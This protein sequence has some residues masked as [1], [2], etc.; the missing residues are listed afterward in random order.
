MTKLIYMVGAPGAGKS[1]AMRSATNHFRR[2]PV[3][4]DPLVSRD[5]IIDHAG[6]V[7]AV[8]LG[9]RRA[10][11]SGTDAL[12]MS[13]IG[14]AEDYLAK[15]PEA[16]GIVLAEG[17]RLANARFLKSALDLGM[18]VSLLYLDNPEAGRWRTQR[19]AQLGKAQNET[20]V[21]GRATAAANLA[22]S[23]PKGVKVVTVGHPHDAARKIIR[24]LSRVEVA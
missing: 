6:K 7:L 11:F 24:A 18:D 9:K 8:E 17:A 13:V 12:G 19:A 3:Y 2:I 4:D 15:L 10:D 22:A 20:W 16:P 23:P 14:Q 1:T 21:R 5:L